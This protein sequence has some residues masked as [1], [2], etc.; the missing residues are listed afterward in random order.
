MY[1]FDISIYVSSICIYISTYG[2]ANMLTRV[3]LFLNLRTV[4]RQASL[5]MKFSRQEYRSG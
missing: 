4:A 3:Q 2:M 1:T 5:P